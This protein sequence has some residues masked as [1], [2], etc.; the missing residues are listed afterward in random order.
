MTPNNA[1]SRFMAREIHP[2]SFVAETRIKRTP[3]IRRHANRLL[4]V[5][6]LRPLMEAPKPRIVAPAVCPA[7]G[8]RSLGYHAAGSARCGPDRPAEAR[9]PAAQGDHS[10]AQKDPSRAVQTQPARS[11]RPSAHGG[12]RTKH[13]DYGDG[14]GAA[15]LP[16]GAGIWRRRLLLRAGD[17]KGWYLMFSTPALCVYS[18]LAVFLVWLWASMTE[19]RPR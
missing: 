3:E 12:Y 13:A 2:L 14:Y 19:R 7:A 6:E 1:V 11:W 17:R 15:V 10:G 18:A 16:R 8:S 4:A 9:S 5:I